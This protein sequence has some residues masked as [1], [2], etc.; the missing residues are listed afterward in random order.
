MDDTRTRL[1][2][3][4]GT[5]RW[6]CAFVPSDPRFDVLWAEFAM[7]GLLRAVR[8]FAGSNARLEAVCFEHRRPAHHRE[9]TRVFGGSERFEQP[10]LGIEFPAVL[11]DRPHLHRQ[12]ELH[13]LLL[14]QA[15]TTLKRLGGPTRYSERLQHYFLARSPS[16]IPDMN[17][18]ARE[19]GLSERSLR[20]KLAEEG[21]S[22][23][24]LV[25]AALENA[26]CT[27]LRDPRSTIQD[28]ARELDFA[29]VTAFHRA[30]RRWSGVTPQEYRQGLSQ[31]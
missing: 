29:D 28:V 12:A 19:L 20:R 11:L 26:A 22:Y 21:A 9:Y 4:A 23:R 27:M 2:E 25:Q 31:R 13:A 18:A 7:V 6:L 15:E 24:G 30:F 8:S 14:K 1:E 17:T 5:A 16:R 3:R 10:F